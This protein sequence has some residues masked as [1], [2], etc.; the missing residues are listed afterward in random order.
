[1]NDSVSLNSLILVGEVTGDEVVFL[2]V[3]IFMLDRT[4]RDVFG[5]LQILSDPYEISCTLRIKMSCQPINFKKLAGIIL[6]SI[7]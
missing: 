2:C 1:M 7:P 5:Y 6:L 4:L 3:P